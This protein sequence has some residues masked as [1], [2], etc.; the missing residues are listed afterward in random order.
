LITLLHL[1][2]IAERTGQNLSIVSEML[3]IRNRDLAEV[4]K[5]DDFIVSD[6]LIGLMLA[7]IS[8][9]KE[10]T[11]VFGD[12]FDPDGSE[13]YLKPIED[14]VAVEQPVGFYTVVESARQRG[15]TALG[16]R[17]HAEANSAERDYG[18]KVNP[19]KSDMLTFTPGDSVIVLSAS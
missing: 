18:V 10:L 17:R 19:R 6:K 3:D 8:E 15:E 7:Q 11:A 5:A 14:Y 16:Y 2:D 4:T 1:R 9:N 12:L 13:I